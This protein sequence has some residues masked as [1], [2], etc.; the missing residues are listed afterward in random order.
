MWIAMSTMNIQVI[1]GVV[2]F[3]EG[4]VYLIISYNAAFLKDLNEI[5]G[6]RN[7]RSALITFSGEFL[8]QLLWWSLDLHVPPPSILDRSRLDTAQCL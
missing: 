6:S 7:I 2:Y 4:S 3:F 1:N 8:Q 5:C